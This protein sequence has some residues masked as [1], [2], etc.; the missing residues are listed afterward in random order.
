MGKGSWLKE[1]A[2]VCL[3]MFGFEMKV[4][5]LKGDRQWTVRDSEREIRKWISDGDKRFGSCA[6]KGVVGI[7]VK[8]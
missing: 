2:S 7:R 6:H 4:A 3:L 8:R 5:V 1:K